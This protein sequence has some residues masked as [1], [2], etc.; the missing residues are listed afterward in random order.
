MRLEDLNGNVTVDTLKVYNLDIGDL[1]NLLISETK[2]I[3]G[4]LNM[5]RYT[6]LDNI[7]DANRQ[8]VGTIISAAQFLYTYDNY[9]TGVSDYTYDD[10][11]KLYELFRVTYP[12]GY[13]F[14]NTVS[15]TSHKYPSLRTSSHSVYSLD[16]I[17]DDIP[18]GVHNKTLGEWI[19]RTKQLYENNCDESLDFNNLKLRYDTKFNGVSCIFE[20]EDNKIV[21]ALTVG[22]DFT[23]QC[24]DITKYVKHMIIDDY[25]GTGKFGLLVKLVMNNDVFSEFKTDTGIE[26][27]TVESAVYSIISNEDNII[28]RDR[29]TAIPLRYTEVD[30]INSPQHLASLDIYNDTTDTTTSIFSLINDEDMVHKLSH[31]NYM[32]DG[33]DI[34]IVDESIR[35][36]LGRTKDRLNYEITY[37]FTDEPQTTKLLDVEFR[38]RKSGVVIPYAIIEPVNF[39]NTP[40]ISK[41]SIGS[42]DRLISLNLRYNDNV[43]IRYDGVAYLD[44]LDNKDNK[45]SEKITIPSV[46]PICG[47]YLCTG[48]DSDDYFKC[49]NP[50]CGCRKIGNI[51]DFIY[52][53]GLNYINQNTIRELYNAKIVM[54]IEDLFTI[55]TKKRDMLKLDGFT[56]DKIN[57]IVE[58]LSRLKSDRFDDYIILTSLNIENVGNKTAR[59]LCNNFSISDLLKIASNHDV[60][61]LLELKG[62]GDKKVN[63]ILQSIMDKKNVLLYLTTHMNIT[64]THHIDSKFSVCFSKV[65]DVSLERDILDVGG[66]IDDSL[67]KDT[68]YLVVKNHEDSSKKIK[69]AF[70]NGTKIITI[71]E[72]PSIINMYR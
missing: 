39:T 22:D 32:C 54:S 34:S 2:T 59:L 26:Y 50:D 21:R 31:N 25:T 45:K 16:L 6:S 58:E 52:G 12:I 41:V 38:V 62:I 14:P 42:I 68:T 51:T 15:V 1:R 47:N 35:N 49:T 44:K 29:L 10:L 63:L 8:L 28:Y 5:A 19:N 72:L 11:C 7:D 57:T 48:K 17:G 37:R 23:N 24:L 3:Q 53:L 60:D 20:V 13:T 66:S 36:V 9:D 67:R 27:N 4:I 33:I 18:I 61:T 65:R 70:D 56:M 55:N 46:C 43:K 30:D 71:D 64:R 40:T 69:K